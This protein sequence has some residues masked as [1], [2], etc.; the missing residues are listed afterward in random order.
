MFWKLQ[1]FAGFSLYRDVPRPQYH[2][3]HTWQWNI[4]ESK[5]FLFHHTS[6]EFT[7]ITSDFRVLYFGLN[8]C[9]CT[10]NLY[11]RSNVRLLGSV[12][13]RSLLKLQRRF[14]RHRIKRRMGNSVHFSLLLQQSLATV[15]SSPTTM[16][17]PAVVMLC[18]CTSICLSIRLSVT[19]LYL[20]LS[21]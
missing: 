15:V 11:L 9:S 2:P 5:T 19:W 16:W 18:A 4:W 14:W 6:S 3:W 1:E 8:L 17:G 10:V 7:N 12:T 20:K 21:R 13:A